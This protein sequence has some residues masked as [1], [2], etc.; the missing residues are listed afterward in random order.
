MRMRGYAALLVL[1]VGAAGGAGGGAHGPSAVKHS[2]SPG[3]QFELNP[4]PP[5]PG[6][7]VQGV[8]HFEKVADGAVPETEKVIDE[9]AEV[10]GAEELADQHRP[11]RQQ[12]DAPKMI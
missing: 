6:E 12:E 4:P 1:G 11:C 7:R 3:A 10:G 8:D 5:C 2:A 9:P